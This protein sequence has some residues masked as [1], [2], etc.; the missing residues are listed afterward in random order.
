VPNKQVTAS[1]AADFPHV[2]T[3]AVTSFSNVDLVPVKVAQVKPPVN[4]ATVPQQAAAS[5]SFPLVH[6]NQSMFIIFICGEQ[7]GRS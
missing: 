5:V 7:V 4:R 1:V 3:F 2:T 6:D